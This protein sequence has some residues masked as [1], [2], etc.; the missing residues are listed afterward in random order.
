MKISE[1]R[2]QYNQQI[3][4]YRE[5]QVLLANRKKELEQKIRTTPDG[6]TLFANEAA[7]L[8]LQINAVNEKQDEY[9]E[10]MDKLLEQWAA[11]ANMESSKQQGEAMEEYYE[12]MGKIMEVARRIM[13]G[14]I[15]PAD[16]EKRLMEYS[17]ELYQAAKNMGALAKER[18]EYDTLWEEEAEEGE[19]ADPMEVADN[20]EAFAAGPEIVD[21]ADTMEAAVAG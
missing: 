3:K 9:R 6:V 18:E 7:T 15:V 17:M 21:V 11:V 8:E 19:P 2:I 4:S 12:D 1:V 14:G 13:K 20:T 10:Y 16:D 5:Q